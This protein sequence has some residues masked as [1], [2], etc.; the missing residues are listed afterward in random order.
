[1]IKSK[2]S[3]KMSSCDFFKSSQRFCLIHLAQCWKLM[4]FLKETKMETL[5]S[6]ACWSQPEV[7]SAKMLNTLVWIHVINWINDDVSPV[8]CIAYFCGLNL[9]KSS[10]CFSFFH[11][12]K[13]H[14]SNWRYHFF[15]G[16]RFQT[17]STIT[18]FTPTSLKHKDVLLD[19][20]VLDISLY[21]IQL[22]FLLSTLST[23]RRWANIILT[24]RHGHKASALNRSD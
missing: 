9:G 3:S 11:F 14:K 2:R 18:E 15:S 22:I 4:S 13:M 12:T 8:S 7:E 10:T 20:R 21:S 17:S 16:S 6:M 24:V 23:T 5:K 1:M 19:L